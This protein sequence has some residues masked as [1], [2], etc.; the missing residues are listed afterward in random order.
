VRL[1]ISYYSK[2]PQK[3]AGGVIWQEAHVRN[4]VVKKATIPQKEQ[5]LIVHRVIEKDPVTKLEP[6]DGERLE[7][8]HGA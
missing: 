3:L 4:E 5:M 6:K 2:H 8:R 7:A 1:Q